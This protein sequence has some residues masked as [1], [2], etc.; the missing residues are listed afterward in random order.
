MRP[1]IDWDTP[2]A[3]GRGIGQPAVRESGTVIADADPDGWAFVFDEHPAVS[4]IARMTMDVVDRCA[5]STADRAR[6]RGGQQHR[7]CRA[8]DRDSRV[9]QRLDQAAHVYLASL[10]VW[11]GRGARHQRPQRNLLLGREPAE[12]GGLAAKHATTAADQR[13]YLKH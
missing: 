11:L 3:R 5:R 4:A 12:F 13:E 6:G 2:P 7:G 9:G 8:C 10:G 1:M